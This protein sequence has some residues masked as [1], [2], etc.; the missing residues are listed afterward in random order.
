MKKTISKIL[1]IVNILVVAF[2][3]V[4]SSVVLSMANTDQNE[5]FGYQ[6]KIVTGEKANAAIGEKCFV[7]LDP[8][9][10]QKN[11]EDHQLLYTLDHISYII[12]AIDKDGNLIFYTD[13]AGER[14]ALDI[15]TAEYGGVVVFSSNFLGNLLFG[16][17]KNGNIS[18]K[19]ILIG[20]LFIISLLILF[21]IYAVHLQKR[22]SQRGSSTEY[23]E[24]MRLFDDDQPIEYEPDENFLFQAEGL[25]EAPIEVPVEQ[26]VEII[27]ISDEEPQLEK[28]EQTLAQIEKC[29]EFFLF[30][31]E[32]EEPIEPP[33]DLLDED[34]PSID[35]LMGLIDSQFEEY[36]EET[37]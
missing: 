15:T 6:A 5:L 8:N 33:S 37:R 19:F 7:L 14:Q 21:I 23:K 12:T 25:I 22:R 26:P 20:G 24:K 17:A 30:Q 36:E 31:K 3:L 13:W 32:T 34:V 9:P 29:R 11:A 27:F 2:L 1:V 28:T 16:I 18:L 10:T 35:S 4:V